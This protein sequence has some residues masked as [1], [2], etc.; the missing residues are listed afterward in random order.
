MPE[1]FEHCGVFFK[2]G[3]CSVVFQKCSTQS[4]I[5]N[6]LRNCLGENIVEGGF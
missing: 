6:F 5:S 4:Q 2:T 1:E 3:T